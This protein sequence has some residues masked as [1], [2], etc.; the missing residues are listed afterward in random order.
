MQTRRICRTRRRRYRCRP[1]LQ[2]PIYP[3]P[4]PA[5]RI[6]SLPYWAPQ[7]SAAPHVVQRPPAEHGATATRSVRSRAAVEVQRSG[8]GNVRACAGKAHVNQAYCDAP[9]RRRAGR[10]RTAARSSGRTGPEPAPIGRRRAAGSVLAATCSRPPDRCTRT[11]LI[12]HG[13]LPG[14]LGRSARAR[15]TPA[16][17]LPNYPEGTVDIFIDGSE[18]QTGRLMLGVGVNSDAGVVGNVVVDERNFDWTRLPTSWE[19]VRNGSAFRGAG[20]RFRIDASPGSAGESLPG[21]L[22]G[23]VL[24]RPADQ[25]GLSGSYFDRRFRDW[26]EQR[27]RPHVAG[28]SV[29]RARSVGDVAYRGENVKI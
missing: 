6:D 15:C 29:G 26:D 24:V 1:N 28:L 13:P 17:D 18:T 12:P 10:R 9:G 22:S 27:R 4:E 25:P 7:R 21:E 20:Q 14:I 8:Y 11:P 2:Q 5:S 3:R 23:A 19:D 16:P